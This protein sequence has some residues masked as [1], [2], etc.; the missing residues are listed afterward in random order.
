[1]ARAMLVSIAAAASASAAVQASAGQERN[2]VEFM[3]GGIMSGPETIRVD[4]DTGKVFH[5]Y[6]IRSPGLVTKTYE[7]TLSPEN[8]GKLRAVARAAVKAGLVKD[9]CLHPP[10]GQPVPMPI[11]DA[12]PDLRVY[13]DGT[14]T[15][16][17]A[18]ITCST[19]A[20][21]NLVATLVRIVPR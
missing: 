19:P 18:V 3:M 8:V 6:A 7:G 5:S 4:L 11:M 2:R 9:S 21:D 12:I 14:A 15:F 10:N 20:A 16:G 1:M 13:V 17:S